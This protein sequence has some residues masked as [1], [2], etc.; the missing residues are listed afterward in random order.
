MGRL[1]EDLR[2]LSLAETGELP[3]RH[4]IV[5]IAE[6]MSDVQTSFSG[7]AETAGIDLQV[8]TN[9]DASKMRIVGDIDRLDQVLS[10]LVAN[11]LRHTDENGVL[12]ALKAKLV[13]EDV[14]IQV[15]DSGKGI[16]PEDLPFVFDRFWRGDRARTHS[17]GAGSGLAP[18]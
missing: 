16:A 13:D 4:E 6:L 12:I 1:V 10:N 11:S 5:S 2:T 3:M 9:G 7:Q 18:T 14:Q 17:D 8:S 15:Q